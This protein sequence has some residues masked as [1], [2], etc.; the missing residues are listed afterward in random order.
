MPKI[1]IQKKESHYHQLI[2]QI[3]NENFNEKFE[4]S[5][6]AVK[7]SND[8]SHLKVYFSFLKNDK[9]SLEFLENAKGFIKRKLA[10]QSTSYKVPELHFELDT[11][12]KQVEKIDKIIQKIH[13]KENK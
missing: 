10:Q 3:I 8:G 7:L 5:I 9:K 2:A 4:V 11:V 6:T 12:A 1:S 13:E